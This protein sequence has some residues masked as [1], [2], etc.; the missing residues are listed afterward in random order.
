M[1][2]VLTELRIG[3]EEIRKFIENS[4]IQRQLFIIV[5]KN[6]NSNLI[7][8][9]HELENEVFN[10]ML[11]YDSFNNKKIFEYN[12]IVISLYGYFENFIEEILKAYIQSLRSFINVFQDMPQKIRD[13]H[14][15]L[16]AQLI[17]NKNI[18][19][20]QGLVSTEKIITNLNLCQTGDP[21]YSINLDAYTYHTSN[22]REGII[23]EFFSKVGIDKISSFILRYPKFSNYLNE[24]EISNSIAFDSINDLADRRNQVAHGSVDNILDID[25]LMGY[26]DFFELYCCSLFEVLF[27]QMLDYRVKRN[28]SQYCL[29]TP[30][31]VYGRNIVCF[32][33]ANV[34]LRQGG[35]LY[36]HTNNAAEII[37][38]GTIQSIRIDDEEVNEIMPDQSCRISIKVDF[39]V[40]ENYSYYTP[41]IDVNESTLQP[42]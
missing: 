19:K 27:M 14:A 5:R 33:V 23:D 18:P 41:I 31:E 6:E 17:Q 13:N 30:I 3:L 40:S 20:Y 1:K 4:K 12:T 2:S 11:H 25:I 9:P 15:D 36:A 22:F 34:H 8:K 10:F 16:S 24:N 35:I 42:V 21:S 32:E 37:R 26:I 38:Y 29:S 39:K 28:I 7:L